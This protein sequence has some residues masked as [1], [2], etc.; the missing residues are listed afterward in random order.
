MITMITSEGIRN[1][2]NKDIVYFYISFY[3]KQINNHL[4]TTSSFS[5]VYS[6]ETNHYV[7]MFVWQRNEVIKKLEDQL[8]VIEVMNITGLNE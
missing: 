8:G 7:D 4:N 2:R 3:K 6:T 5:T 1:L